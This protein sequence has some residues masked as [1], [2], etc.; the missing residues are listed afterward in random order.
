MK[1]GFLLLAVTIGAAGVGEAGLIPKKQ[2]KK[3]PPEPSMLDKYV[4]SAMQN[5]AAPPPEPQPGALWSPTARL[6]DFASDPRAS[7]LNDV[8]TI[9]VTETI[10]AVA[11]G[12]SQTQRQTTATETIPQLVG[13]KSST[14]ALTN[15][16]NQAGNQQ[17]NGQGTT[18]RTATL[19]ATM[20]ARVVA[21][22]PGGLLVIEGS[23][24]MQVNSEE[25][26]ISVRGVIRTADITTTNTVA[27][28]Q[29][30]DMEIRVNGKGVVGDAIRRP[31][32]LYRLLMGLL[33]F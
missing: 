29:I 11:G 23:K 1:L 33:P 8:V 25:Q 7:H 26:D 20:T 30:A 22:L 12:V 28:T 6:N 27:S 19:N 31:N 21:V 16:L 10:N 2:Q 18:S 5:Q 9:V 3:N 32:F 24:N 14:G 17:L 4:S 15:L 13:L